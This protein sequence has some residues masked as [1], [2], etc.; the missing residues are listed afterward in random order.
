M[1]GLWA[2]TEQLAG[3]FRYPLE[4]GPALRAGQL[5]LYA[6]W[7][8][9]GW[10][11][12]YGSL[13]PRAFAHASDLAL[14]AAGVPM[15]AAI[16][17]TARTTRRPKPFGSAAW[18]DRQD[19]RKAAL[20][21][22]DGKVSGRVLGRFRGKLLTYRGD[23]HTLVV[24]GTRSGKGA[25]HVIPSV[26]AYPGSL[27]VY[28]RK[29]EI[30]TIT[31][32]HRKRF[33]HVVRFEPTD[34]RTARWNPL[35]E[36]RKGPFEVADTQNL[37]AILADPIGA[38]NANFDFWD[39][40]AMA[41]MV[42]LI[43][44]V[45]YSAPDAS[46]TLAHVRQLLGDIATTLDDMASTQHSHRADLR[47]ADGFARDADGELIPQVHPEVKLGAQAFDSMSANVRA[48]VLSTA[49]SLL[50]LFADPLVAYA[51][52]ASDFKLSD[53]VCSENPVSFYLVTPMAHADR[54]AFLVRLM[55]RMTLGALMENLN[56]DNQG[57]AKRHRMLMVLDE[58]P[59]LG[60]L[61]FLQG[62]FGEMA[63]YG[64]SGML[65][66]QSFSDIFEAYGERTSFSDNIEITACFATSMPKNQLEIVQ[67]AGKAREL[68][69]G[70]SDPSTLLGSGHRTRSLSER[71]EYILSEEDVRALPAD[72]QFLFVQ[73]SKPIVAKK[74]RYFAE[75]HFKPLATDIAKGRKPKFIQDGRLPGGLDLP[76]SPKLSWKGVVPIAE[77]ARLHACKTQPEDADDL[78]ERRRNAPLEAQR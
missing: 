34:P 3:V 51:T 77:A 15:L 63:G 43:L 5:H 58:F 10:Y 46:K 4:F 55:V 75:P 14:L 54:L 74:I 40:E 37:V 49:R 27:F 57:R 30:Y 69:E 47:N 73:N 64:V 71:R 41:F 60:K 53:L 16:A 68:R 61:P 67:R 72:Q 24:G 6:P 39:K 33:S 70:F 76:R 19:V 56:H 42:G 28:D 20:I 9:V 25:G 36:I 13:Y 44:H 21:A 7:S 23:A 48:G 32:D 22:T 50:S 78:P 31:A 65:V 35:M 45:L 26:L 2:A 52:S 38:K 8:G 62:A 1:L 59:K 17:V 29:G 11:R 12:A 18:A 66:C